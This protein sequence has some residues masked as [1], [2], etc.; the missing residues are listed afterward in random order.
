MGAVTLPS[1][2]MR[3]ERQIREQII[4][5]ER[6]L[7]STIQLDAPEL[8]LVS[9]SMLT[10]NSPEHIERCK[11][12]ELRNEL[13]ALHGVPLFKQMNVLKEYILCV[14][15][16]RV[17]AMYRS[18]ETSVWTS[19]KKQ[20]RFQYQQIPLHESG[21]EVRKV[22]I[23][24]I[25]A[26][27]ALGLDYGV[28]ICGIGSGKHVGVKKIVTH[29]KLN[30]KMEAA[31]VRAIQDYANL[32]L[33]PRT[34]IHQI[35][36]GADPEF[37]VQSNRGKLVIASKYFPKNGRVG[38]DDI[39]IGQ[40]HANKPVVEIRPDPTSD[41][42]RLMAN[43]YQNLLYATKKIGHLPATWLAG[44]MPYKG[45]PLG[46]H[47]HFSGIQPNFKLLR[48]LDNYLALPF[49]LAEDPAGKKRRPK[50][51]YLGDFRY[52]E[53]GGFEYRTL[54]SWLVSPIL[55]KGAFALAKLIGAYYHLLQFDPLSEV[56]MQRAYYAGDKNELRDWFEILW[57]DLKRLKDY[58]K[59]EVLL[60]DF[61]QYITSGRTWDETRDIRKVWRLPPFASKKS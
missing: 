40:N 10:L 21:K 22:Q 28:V 51:G 61:Y 5:K 1:I 4:T 33:K 12:Q 38:C 32:L 30:D 35:V 27:Y 26:I 19:L 44:S 54:P 8:R 52:Q 43:I 58:E 7:A 39:W 53:H 16:T 3:N 45:F 37:V 34:P 6:K 18:K 46:G 29:P 11:N 57:V 2:P 31:Y 36:L 50:Y 17:V 48:A 47:I 9:K 24:A 41:P 49:I 42:R 13:L 59:H 55:T 15:Q 14:F 20:K 56:K 60:E 23:L 25:R